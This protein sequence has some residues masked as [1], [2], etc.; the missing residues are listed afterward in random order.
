MNLH[1]STA[2]WRILAAAAVTCAAALA[3]AAA[4]ASTGTHAGPARTAT[5]SCATSGLDIWMNTQGN[6]ALGTTYYHLE[7]TNL[8]G[9]TCTLFGY[10]GVSGVTLTGTQLG[11]AAS[12]NGRTPH[13]VTLANGAT[14]HALVGIVEAG[15][16]P[17]SQCGPVTAAGLRV[18][19]PNQTQSRVAPYPFP[20]CSKS[21][22]LY[23][24]IGPMQSGT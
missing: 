18:Y 3:P 11:S 5:P 20:A 13:T 17:P 24:N 6:G 10:P 8:S 23:L 1:V 16:F 14:A 2:A 19:P 15:N 7:I 4:L 21:G 12:R 22:P 9:S